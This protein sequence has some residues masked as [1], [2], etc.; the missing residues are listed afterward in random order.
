MVFSLTFA[1]DVEKGKVFFFVIL[2][3]RKEKTSYLQNSITD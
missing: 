3:L 2:D 1:D